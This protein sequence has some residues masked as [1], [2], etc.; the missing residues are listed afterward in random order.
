MPCGETA[1][2][3]AI[4]GLD[5]LFPAQRHPLAGGFTKTAI[6]QP[7]LTAVFETL[8]PATECSFAHPQQLRSLLLTEFVRLVTTKHTPKPDHPHTLQRF[9][10]AHQ[11]LQRAK[12]TGQIVC[13]LNR[14]YRVLLTWYIGDTSRP[15][16]LAY[17]YLSVLVAKRDT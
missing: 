6:Q 5:L 15:K 3:G 17:D 12:I 2:A 8:T 10:T 16:S 9:R 13:Y 4:Q 11:A 7:G 1:V 14:T